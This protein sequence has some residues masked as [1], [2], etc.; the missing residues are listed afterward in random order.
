MNQEHDK[1]DAHTIFA[2]EASRNKP[3]TIGNKENG[4]IFPTHIA[5]HIPHS[6]INI[7]IPSGVLS[8]SL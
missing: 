1:Q 4:Y 6:D 7:S 3:K 2:E 5:V 8:I